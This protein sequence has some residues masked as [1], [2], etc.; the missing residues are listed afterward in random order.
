MYW[1]EA[2]LD[3]DFRDSF[4]RYGV[5]GN[6]TAKKVRAVG[7]FLFGENDDPSGI[8]LDN[9]GW[10]VEVDAAVRDD[11]VLYLRWDEFSRDLAAGGELE[12]DGP[13]LGVSWLSSELTRITVEVQ[14][15]DTD[16]TSEDSLTAEMQ[17][18]F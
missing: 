8:Q 5:L 15:L 9:N 3:D 13:T 6:Y 7:G 2:V 12:T 1:G 10:F 14:T 4:N 16:S 17:I 18:T 11:T